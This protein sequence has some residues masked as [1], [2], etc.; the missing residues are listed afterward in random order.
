MKK[1]IVPAVFGEH[2]RP[3]NPL[4]KDA[5]K[6]TGMPFVTYGIS[7]DEKIEFP[8]TEDDIVVKEQPIAQ[9]RPATQRLLLV[10]RIDKNG[11]RKTSWLSLGILNRTD[12]HRE[13]TCDFCAKMNDF[14]NDW[15]R[16]MAN[17]GKTITCKRTVTKDFQKF[18]R[19]TGTRLEGQIDPRPTPVIEYV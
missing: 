10:D 13:P 16:I 5:L 19:A 17:L 7:V 4:T 12:F 18:D 1:T 3:A 9:N 8:D 15:D 11:N 6:T 2:T 14:E